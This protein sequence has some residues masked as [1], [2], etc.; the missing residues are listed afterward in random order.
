MRDR[1]RN[2]VIQ[3]ALSILSLLLFIFSIAEAKVPDIVLKHKK[4]VVTIYGGYTKFS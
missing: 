3:K 1:I 2:A 4:A